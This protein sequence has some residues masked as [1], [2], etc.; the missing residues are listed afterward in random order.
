MFL[1]AIFLTA[2]SAWAG[3]PPGL[4]PP[5]LD[6]PEPWEKR[7]RVL[8]DGPGPCVELQGQVR[9]Q[10]SLFMPGGFLS[11]GER[12]DVVTVGRFSGALEAGTWVRMDLAWDPPPE[13]EDALDV[14]LFH[15]VIGRM[16]ARPAPAEG[17]PA[18]GNSISVSSGKGGGTSIVVGDSG[19]EALG[20]LDDV[21]AQV[22]PEVT[23]SYVTW[24]EG[25]R[26][27]VLHQQ[28]PLDEGGELI[29]KTVFP[30]NG[31]PVS[32]DATFPRQLR[33]GERP[34]R[35]MV[36]DAQIHL[37]GRQTDLGMLPGAEGMSM[38][39][40]VMGFTFGVDQRIVYER[41]RSCP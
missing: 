22:Q 36:R 5:D 7:A 10:L 20:L 13:G 1:P 11:P 4:S 35:I 12:H 29:L 23:T 37:R 30:E 8:L 31:P 15:P 24:E 25:Q 32:I 26:A 41:A 14:K 19:E 27:V 3:L 2:A 28:M 18:E 16:P 33:F 38:V 17:A 40:G 34:F 39:L 9:V 21:L 6:D